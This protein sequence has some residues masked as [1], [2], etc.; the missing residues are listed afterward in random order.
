MNKT[1]IF[2]FF[3]FTNLAFAQKISLQEIINLNY[4]N[5]DDFDTF[6]VARGYIFSKFE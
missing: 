1:I 2:L 3:V 5:G 4:K 6:V